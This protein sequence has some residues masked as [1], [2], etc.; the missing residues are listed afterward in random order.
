MWNQIRE[1]LN[2][3]VVDHW[4]KILGGVTLLVVGRL[5]GRWRA[6]QAWKRRE[7]KQRLNISLNTVVDGK[8]RIRTLLET[9]MLDV[10]LNERAVQCVREAADQTTES[11]PILPL[12]EDDRWHVLNAVLNEIAE[13]FKE[14][15]IAADQ[16]LPVQRSDYAF[17]MVNEVAGDM[18]T[19]KVR[20]MMVRPEVLEDESID[21]DALNV[22]VDHHRTRLK[23][24]KSMRTRWRATN[25]GDFAVVEITLRS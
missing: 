7:F 12:P 24:L 20:V 18:K 5:W 1:I 3:L 6:S 21:F 8:L 25:R 19:R 9:D 22:E 17:C 14:G 13:Q 4:L 16:G 10:L 2:D 15:L 23:T 11:Q